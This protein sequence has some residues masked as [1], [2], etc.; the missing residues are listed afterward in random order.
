MRIVWCSWWCVPLLAAG[1][2][3]L[4]VPDD[5]PVDEGRKNL[6]AIRE[7]LATYPPCRSCNVSRRESQPLPGEPAPAG[8]RPPLLLGSGDRP[9]AR[10]SSTAGGKVTIPLPWKPSVPPPIAPQEPFH[11]VPPYLNG[12]PAAPASPSSLRCV[13]DFSGGQRCR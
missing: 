9:I 12:I 10:Q 2:M 11:P 3:A 4:P 13:P 6:E 5:Q 1:C 8:Y 7:I